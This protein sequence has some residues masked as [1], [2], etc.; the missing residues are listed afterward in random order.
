M[1]PEALD[2]EIKLRVPRR[3]KLQFQRLARRQGV[4]PAQLQREAY[5]R[6]LASSNQPTNDNNKLSQ[7]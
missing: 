6:Y 3:M 4:R 1:K 5:R 7:V 2:V